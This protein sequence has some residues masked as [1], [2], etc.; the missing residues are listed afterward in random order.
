MDRKEI[1]LLTGAAGF[2]GSNICR[3]LV[4]N[5]KTVR[6]LVLK[7][8]KA[9]AFI[10]E[11]VQKVEGDLCSEED[12]RAF[13]DV[14]DD[15]DVYVIHC[16]SIVTVNPEFNPKVMAVNVGGTEN[17]L[18]A[19]RDCKGFRKLVY[20]GSTGA[21][22]TLPKGTV[23]KEIR[24]FAPEAVY[25]CYS[26]SKAEASNLVLDAAAEGL[27][28]C[29]VMP[30]G[31]LG[32]NDKSFSTTTS[33]VIRIL[34]GEMS[35]GIA[36]SFN[37]A[38]VRDLASGVIAAIEK[39]RRGETYILGNNVVSFK[40]FAEILHEESGCPKIHF[41]LPCGFARKIAARME[42]KARK[43][44]SKPLLTTYSIDVLDKNNAYDSSKAA[45]ELGYRCRP[46]KD[47]IRDEVKWLQDQRM[48]G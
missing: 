48:L 42:A 4:N 41:F 36:G 14:E 13:F 7:G 33:T 1:Y 32:P 25:D 6:A 34:K 47:T 18:N 28:A 30:T 38:D 31:I 35:M 20:V 43:T 29:I 15:T 10:P 24:R 11:G 46:Y 44:G 22:P 16:A 3:Q 9:A 27:N 39:G 40:E 12:I 26:K 23:H 8:D 5:G 37:M 19:C 2:L 17:I 45:R 21:I